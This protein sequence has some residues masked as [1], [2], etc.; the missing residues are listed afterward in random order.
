MSQLMWRALWVGISMC[1]TGHVAAAQTISGLVTDPHGVVV[2]DAEVFVKDSLCCKTDKK[3]YFAINNIS[4]RDRIRITVQSPYHYPTS[5]ELPPRT[6]N[7]HLQVVLKDKLIGLPEL[8]VLAYHSRSPFVETSYSAMK[9]GNSTLLFPGTIEVLSRSKLEEQQNLALGDALKNVA[10]ISTASAGEANN[11]SEQFISRGFSMSN[12]RN[13]FRDGMRYRKVAH[14]TMMGI[15]R[16]ELLRGPSSVLYGSVEPG[17]IVNIITSPSL[18]SPRYSAGLRIGSYGLRQVSADLTGPLSKNKHIRY[19]LN[20]LYEYADSY[21]REVYTERISLSPRLDLSISPKTSL[22][23]RANLFTDYR[24]VDPGIVHIKGNIIPNGHKLFV[25]EPWAY[26]SYRTLDAGYSL[27]HEFS[28]AWRLHSQFVY[29][30]LSE[31]RLYFQMKD[32]KGDIMNRRLAKWDAKIDYYTLQNDLIGA[33]RTGMLEHQV[34]IGTEYEFAHNLR[35]VK[36]NNFSA[37]NLTKP[38]Y[39]SKPNDIDKYKKSTDLVIDQRNFALY[40]QDYIGLGKNFKLLLGGRLDWINET[41]T[42]RL[43]TSDQSESKAQPLAFSPRLALMY[44][45]QERMSAYLSYTSSYVPASGLSK[46]GK[47]FDPIRTRQWELGFKKRLFNNSTTL[48]LALYKMTKY[49]LLTPD[50]E[51]PKYRVQIGE[52]Y[53]RGLELSLASRLSSSW[54]LEGSYAYTEGEV[55]KTNDKAIPLGSK[56]ANVPKHQLSLWSSYSIYQGTL[57]GLSFGGGAFVASSSFANANNSLSF[58]S[59]STFDAFVSYRRKHYKIA[60]NAKNITDKRYYLGAQ[61]AN[62]FTL[63]P[64]RM[65]ILSTTINL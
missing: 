30:T 16:I 63:A 41:Q 37:I 65:F 58:E 28:S 47:P 34:L 62:L 40:A 11:V 54:T 15:E 10:G 29:T 25:G 36:G 57:R 17:G 53:S 55:S 60:L 64:P 9:I 8:D 44:Q 26:S 3:G 1:I 33:F 52:Q 22:S 4:S 59:R 35:E 21:R 19:R 23:L 42:N 51:D 18:Y 7:E 43:K 2:Q 39:T 14:T 61:G 5:I 27:K 12:S 13:Y 32:I 45:T 49:N 6:K 20:G 50:L 48:S 56:L 31:D 24:V 46:E 38:I